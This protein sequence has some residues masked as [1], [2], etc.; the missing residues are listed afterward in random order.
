M[1]CF[2]TERC[3]DFAAALSFS[4]RSFDTRRLTMTSSGDCFR[5][6]LIIFRREFNVLCAMIQDSSYCLTEAFSALLRQ[7]FQPALCGARYLKADD[8][9]VW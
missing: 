1:M 7:L 2:D 9:L 3:S 5:D 6:F 8:N 4:D